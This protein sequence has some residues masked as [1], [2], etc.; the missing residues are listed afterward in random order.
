VTP[1]AKTARLVPLAD[2]VALARLGERMRK[3]QNRFFKQR[4]EQPQM[5][6]DTLL[7]EARAVEREFDAAVAAAIARD[8][9]PAL[10][11]LDDAL[12]HSE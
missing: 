1:D 8:K 6:D 9:Q 3:A 5:S 4:R 10:P 12:F 7:R 11:D 2:L